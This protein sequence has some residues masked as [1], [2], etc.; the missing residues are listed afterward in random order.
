MLIKDSI[1]QE[2][3]TVTNIYTPNDRPAKH[4]MQKLI[5]LMGEIDI[6]TIIV[7]DFTTHLQ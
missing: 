7:K 1:H 6:S 2:D 3:I 4:M 5:K